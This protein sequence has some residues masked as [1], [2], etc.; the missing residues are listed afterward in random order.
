MEDVV[1]EHLNW[2][3][4]QNSRCKVTKVFKTWK[5]WFTFYS[6]KYLLGFGMTQVC[7]R[8]WTES[9]LLQRENIY[10]GEQTNNGVMG[11]KM[12]GHAHAEWKTASSGYRRWE[13]EGA[14]RNK[15]QSMA[16]SSCKD[17]NIGSDKRRAG[18][19]SGVN[20]GLGS[21]RKDVSLFV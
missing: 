13:K 5:C 21:G 9:K 11:E 1:H 18:G 3:I 17:A 15:V 8:G 20:L 12:S 19:G 14:V 7:A 6:G 16:W 10:S 4:R 2:W